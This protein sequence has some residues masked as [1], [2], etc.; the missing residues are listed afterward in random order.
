MNKKI[1][2]YILYTFLLGKVL[3]ML[4]GCGTLLPTTP[5]ATGTPLHTPTT[6]PPFFHYSS[7]SRSD[8]YLEFEYPSSWS[9]GEDVQGDKISIALYEPRFSTLPTPS[10]DDYHPTPNDFGAIGIWIYPLTSS[11]FGVSFE[12]IV[13]EYAYIKENNYHITV[14]S[15]Y[16]TQFLG[17]DAIVMEYRLH[18]NYA[19]IH[20]SEMFVKDIFFTVNGLLYQIRFTIAEKD[21]GNE[22]E[23]GYEYFIES[24][25]ITP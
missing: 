6:T 17:F 9:F 5:L 20:I 13:Q 16:K 1:T 15:N 4:I 14:L 23:Q 22:F 8:I 18:E 2:F 25:K 11:L 7:V 12:E 21:R 10:P 19:E 3:F 24:L